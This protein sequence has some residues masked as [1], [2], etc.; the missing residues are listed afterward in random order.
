M[1][2]VSGG[3]CH[4]RRPGRWAGT[5]VPLRRRDPRLLFQREGMPLVLLEA[6][7]MA[8]PTV[9]AAISGTRD[10]IESEV[11]TLVPFGDAAALRLAPWIS[12]RVPG[13][14]PPG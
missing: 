6:M 8:S 3:S 12:R 10:L 2:P 13:R 4:L 9:A 7:A 14:R 5:P 1:L 11:G